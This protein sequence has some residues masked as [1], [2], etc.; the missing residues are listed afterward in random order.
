MIPVV[1]SC[2][3]L[4]AVQGPDSP[5]AAVAAESVPEAGAEEG[6]DEALARYSEQKEKTP[7]TAAAQWKLGLWCEQNGLAAEAYVAFLGRRAARPKA[8]G[9]LAEAR[10]QE[11]RR[12]VDDRRADRRGQGAE[13]GRA[14]SG[15]RG[16]RRSTRTSTGPTGPRSRRRPGPR[17]TR[18]PT[19]RRSRRS[20]ASSAAGASATRRSPIQVLGQIDKPVASK[21][22]AVLA[23]YGKTPEVRRRATE[24]L[25]GGEPEEFLDLLVGLMI[26]P[27]K[28]EVKP[29]GGPG[30]PGVLFVEGEKFNVR[31][32]YA[33]PPP[34]N[35][36]PRPGD[37][38]T[39]DQFGMPVI[40]RPL[41][42]GRSHKAGVPGSK[43]L[44][45]RERTTRSSSPRPRT[46]SR[47][48]GPRR[49]RRP[50][51][52]P[53]WRRSRPSTTPATSSTTWSS[54]SSRT[55]PA[56]ISARPPRNGATPSGEG[57]QV[58]ATARPDAPEADASTRW[59]PWATVPRSRSSAF[60][61]QG[62][63]RHLTR[64][65][66]IASGP[67]VPPPQVSPS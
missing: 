30:S 27:L 66:P 44:V 50:S 16:S 12:P 52:K 36:A 14:R 34:P 54:A 67:E 18:S 32:F 17:S 4:L 7:E 58:R 55:R 53:T 23:V 33:P 56:R 15:R 62:R 41:G 63:R 8:R 1:L 37:M 42:A 9:G 28:Y 20:I 47:P 2:L 65:P 60:I 57:E 45:Y 61:T 11:A 39:Y 22:L 46:C 31:R 38:V 19:R 49:R 51:S 40:T 64:A 5:P 35:V 29:V 10:V 6:R 21:V 13:E 3:T 59:C 43:S 25:R 24:T 48:S 26:D